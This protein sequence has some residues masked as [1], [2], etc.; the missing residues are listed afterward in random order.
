VS[1]ES[2]CSVYLST[3]ERIDCDAVLCTVSLGVLKRAV[4]ES[5][6][7]ELDRVRSIGH[8]GSSSGSVSSV[9]SEIEVEIAGRLACPGSDPT[10]LLPSTPMRCTSASSSR[11]TPARGGGPGPVRHPHPH[12]HLH[13]HPDLAMTGEFT[14][15][16]PHPPVPLRNE[17]LHFVPVLPDWK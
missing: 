9:K 3:G 16:P 11:S 1:A 13:L 17:S 15:P 14:E 8:V 5:V 7:S 12:P 2:P 4:A 10:Q 6:T